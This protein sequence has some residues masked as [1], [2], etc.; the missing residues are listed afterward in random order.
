MEFGKAYS[1]PISPK[2]GQVIRPV[3]VYPE[4]K[5]PFDERYFPEDADRAIV[6]KKP[7]GI[8]TYPIGAENPAYP[9]EAPVKK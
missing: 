3:K 9:I 1:V 8:H 7:D 6:I 5:L 4:R 2:A